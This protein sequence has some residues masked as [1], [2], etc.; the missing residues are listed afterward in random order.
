M[1]GPQFADRNV[2]QAFA[3]LPEAA[4]EGLLALRSMI[5]EVAARHEAVGRIE[6]TLKWGQPAYLTPET[7]AGSTIRLG[8]P[9]S[10]GHDYALFVHCQ[11]DLTRQFETNYPGAFD[12][13]GTRALLFKA[14]E[15]V[16]AEAMTHCIGLA[17]TY[18]RRK[19][20]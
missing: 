6:E 1:T 11:T 3:A 4:R 19:W 13:E 12:F 15:P 10:A 9:K 18:H 17:L 7:G 2:E 14:G 20:Q 5:F 8:V 16:D